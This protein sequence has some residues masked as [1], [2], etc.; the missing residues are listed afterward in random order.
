MLHASKHSLHLLF[1]KALVQFVKSNIS[2]EE[3]FEVKVLH[4]YLKE[5]WL[6]LHLLSW[7]VGPLVCLI[8]YYIDYCTL[9]WNSLHFQWIQS[10]D[11]N[12]FLFQKELFFKKTPSNHT[13]FYFFVGKLDKESQTA[14]KSYYWVMRTKWA[15]LV[16]SAFSI[17]VKVF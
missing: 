4:K 6:F 8:Q 2:A 7:N 13:F 1:L 10:V 9:D 15:C 14:S 16:S 3:H 11:F 12:S 17:C 5:F